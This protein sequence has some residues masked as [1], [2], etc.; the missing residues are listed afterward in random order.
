MILSVCYRGRS[1]AVP[2]LLERGLLIADVA[3]RAAW[4]LDAGLGPWTLQRALFP[5]PYDEEVCEALGDGAIC[6]LI[7]VPK[8]VRA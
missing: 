7:P 2:V 3:H 6:D 4:L 8:E 5:I 1:V